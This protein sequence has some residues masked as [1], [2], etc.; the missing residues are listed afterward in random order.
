MFCISLNV[1]LEARRSSNSHLRP[2][3][4]D[5]K[6]ALADGNQSIFRA[7][8]S[9]LKI[10]DE[11]GQKNLAH[12]MGVER[13][14]KHFLWSESPTKLLSTNQLGHST[15]AVPDDRFGWY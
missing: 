13:L 4:R 9:A 12:P 3:C 11:T 2:G 15:L 10:P 1:L 7:D 8:M 5:H 6:V 14:L